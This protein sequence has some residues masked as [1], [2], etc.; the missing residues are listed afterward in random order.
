MYLL[1]QVSSVL[2]STF[3]GTNHCTGYSDGF[4][5]LV[6]PIQ[7]VLKKSGAVSAVRANK[8]NTTLRKGNI[9]SGV[10]KLVLFP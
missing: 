2:S 6:G 7:M 5:Q 3:G 8:G 1:S 9:L 10:C 4:G